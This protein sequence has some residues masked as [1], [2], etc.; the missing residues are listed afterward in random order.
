MAEITKQALRVENN[1]SFPNNN[2]GEITP[3]DLRGFN[4]NMIDSLVDEITYNADS[5]SW[6]AQI[7][8]ISG[9]LGSDTEALNEFTASQIQKNATL[10]S[11]TQSLFAADT[12][13]STKFNTIGTQSGSWEN[14]PL[15][16]L[17][18]FTQSQDTKNSTLALYTASVD[19]KFQTIGGQSGSWENIPLTSLNSFTQSQE[20]KNSTLASYTGSNDTKWNTL[21]GQS[22]SFVTESETGSFARV[23]VQ[24]TFTQTQ[25]INADLNVSG[26]INAYKIN[27]TIESSS[28]IYSSGS[29]QFGDASDDVQTLYG[30][31]RVVNQLTA[32]GL[33]YP[34]TDGLFADQVLQ[35]DAAGNLSFGD[36]N[37]IYE[38]I[39]N[40]DTVPLTKGMIVYISGSQGANPLV[41][42]ANS[43]DPTKMPVSHV[44]A[45]TIALNTVG[46]GVQLGLLTGVDMSGIV[47]GTQLWADGIGQLTSVRPTGSLDIVQ[48]VAVVVKTGNGGAIDVLNPGPIL[49]PNLA[50]GNIWV[51]NSSNQAIAI[52]TSS[53]VADTTEL[54]AYTASNDTKWSTLGGQTGSYARTN[55]PN[56]F[57]DVN[58]F[59]STSSFFNTVRLNNNI[60]G[61]TNFVE[62]NVASSSV[63]LASPA[64]ST[65]IS[66]LAHLQSSS[67][68]T[69]INLMLK[70]NNNNATTI[71]SGS[72]NLF[73]NPAAATVGLTRYIGNGN[74]ALNSGNVPQISGSMGFSPTVNNNYFGGNATTLTMR[75]PVTSS[76]AWSIV[77]NTVLG[78]ANIGSTAA[79]NAQGLSS[80]LTYQ[81]NTIPGTF[82]VIANHAA[83]ATAPTIAQNYLGGTSNILLLSSSATF[84]NNTISDSAFNYNN[85]Y[86]SQSIGLGTT[87][88]A[89]NISIGQANSISLFGSN[90]VGTLTTP[91]IS[92][93]AIFGGS[94][95]IYIDS[96]NARVNGTT[97]YNGA[98]RNTLLGNGLTVSGS[99]L[100]TDTT[101]FGS[102]FV[103][104]FNSNDGITNKSSD[105][106]FA[107]GTGTSTTVRKTGL[108][109][110]SGSNT[111]VEGTLNVSGSTTFNGSISDTVKVLSITSLT[112]SLD[113]SVGNTFQLSLVNATDTRLEVSNARQGQ[114]LNLLVSQS[115]GGTGTLSFGSNL[116]ESSGSF[117]SASVVANAK[118]I[119]T[120]ATFVET[121]V[122]YVANIKNLIL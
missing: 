56:I 38:N 118:D 117:Y 55:A 94:N 47:A 102:A 89:R 23:N 64:A 100:A 39:R 41:Y 77:A 65:G 33:R 12:T 114:T 111:Y 122:I 20:T 106:V 76:G 17:N 50:T 97:V 9:A 105:T 68:S 10:A 121:D 116:Y 27:T 99:S 49:I 63:T 74:I 78:T 82:N 66:G 107:V 112:A 95:L 79:N 4:E 48:P 67:P 52:P 11:V 70:D 24:N 90:P 110:D 54:N 98:L 85:Q 88:V 103:G 40:G 53:L 42:R 22:G 43:A 45:E 83:L 104:R 30:S 59:N 58:Q 5:A 28:V 46:R 15:T 34:T 73:V 119:I 75:G 81:L 13:F 32:S 7:L 14:V 87:S 120:L 25:I 86:Y 84:A 36:V 18:T 72:N 35:T 113:A 69:Q 71:V 31:V 57:T 108:R 60:F 96:T 21:G 101:S 26:T 61:A 19:T 62:L 29:N 91:V 37:T 51:G 1:T 3:T 92:D 16:S 8:I 115:A 109:I 6:N 93:N 80:G 2:S 44:V